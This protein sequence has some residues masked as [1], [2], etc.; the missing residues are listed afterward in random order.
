MVIKSEI[1]KGSYYD[2]VVLMLLQRNLADLPEVEDA[3]VIMGT[4]AN[5]ELLKDADLLTK[6]GEAAEPDDLLIVVKTKDNKSADEALAQVEG[7]IKQRKT[8][9]EQDF[10]PK[11]LKAASKYLPESNLVIV[12]VPGRYAAKVAEDALNLGKNVFLYSDNVSIDDEIKLKKKGLDMGLLVMGPDCGTAIINGIGLG[13]ANHVKQ[14]NIGLIGASGTGLQAISSHI[15]NLGGGISHAIGTGGRDL[16][17]QIGAITTL[18]A[19]DFLKN[20]QGTDVC[21]IV[22]KPPSSE[23]ATHVISQARALDMPVVIYFIGYPTPSKSVGNIHFG[24]NLHDAANKAVELSKSKNSKSSTPSH[25]KLGYLRGLF[26]GG[27]LAYESV[28]GLQPFLSPLFTNAPIIKSQ[29][30]ENP[31]KSKFHTIVDLGEDVFTVGRLHPMMDNDLRIKRL[32][33]EVNDPETSMILLDVVLGEGSHPDPASELGPEIRAAKK[34]MKDL[35]I[36]VIVIGT[37]DDPQ[38]K[39]AQIEQLK[40]AGAKVFQS[41]ISAIEY[42]AK[43]FGVSENSSK[44]KLVD[45]LNQSLSAINIGLESFYHSLKSQGAD[46]IHVDWRPPAGGNE[47]L[48]GILEKMN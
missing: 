24:I 47:K 31:L 34:L 28:L 4:P 12:S 6:E 25:Q 42:I 38:D 22:S 1:R 17:D 46:V 11:S 30:L 2:S 39:A 15:N 27:T 3:G 16:K 29:I 35:E 33:Q 26:S 5:K 40:V 7:L 9:I 32:Q 44:N 20:D 23:I 48:M 45:G 37:D 18:Q 13:F 43:N 19:L 10:Q 14:G 41:T 36:V 21:V 8:T